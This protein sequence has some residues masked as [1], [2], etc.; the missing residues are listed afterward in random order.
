MIMFLKLHISLVERLVDL[1][2][3]FLIE[4]EIA[5]LVKN[6]YSII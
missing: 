2:D 1:L 3:I 6:K 5:D 4:N